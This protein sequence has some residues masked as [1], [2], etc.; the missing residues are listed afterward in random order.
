MVV[1]WLFGAVTPLRD[2]GD[3]PPIQRSIWYCR[4]GA[5]LS[6]IVLGLLSPCLRAQL[7]SVLWECTFRHR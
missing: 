3:L 7:G 4:N 2:H 5:S 1:E 6:E